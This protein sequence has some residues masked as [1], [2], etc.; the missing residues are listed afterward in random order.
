[1]SDSTY[2]GIPRDKIPWYPTID[3]NLCTGCGACM[4][5][6]EHD[7]YAQG[8]S[9]TIVANPYNC[10]V[11]CRACSKDCPVDAISFPSKDELVKLLHELRP[12]YK[13]MP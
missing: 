3:A 7:V 12:Q 11:G 2:M 13:S 10:V 4:E 6:C 5:F 8:E 1:M 9:T